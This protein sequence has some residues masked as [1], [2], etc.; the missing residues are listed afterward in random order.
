LDDCT[1]DAVLAIVSD[2]LNATNRP[3]EIPEPL[4]E[5]AKKGD[6]EAIGR[7]GTMYDYGQDFPQNYVEAMRWYR[8]SANKGNDLSMS[9]IGVLYYKGLGV[10]AEQ[11]RGYQ[12]TINAVLRKYM[13]AIKRQAV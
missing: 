1:G 10:P 13:E 3:S 5:A 12:T 8:A 2:P 6:S 11:C 9:R 4:W 7:I